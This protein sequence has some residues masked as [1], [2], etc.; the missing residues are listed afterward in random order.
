M[1]K[2]GLLAFFP[3]I[4]VKR[5]HQLISVFSS[6]DEAWQADA[7][8]F[9]KIKWNEQLIEEFVNW[10]KNIDENQTQKILDQENIRCITI[11]N[12]D[13]PNLLK[14]IY[15]P[16]FALFIK[17]EL[18]NDSF[19][20]A[21]V[22]TRKFTAYGKQITQD[23]VKQLASQGITIISGLALGIDSIA[24]ESALDVK[25]KTIAV[26]GSGIDEHHIYPAIHVNLAK[27]IIAGG[28]AIISEYPPGTEPT[29]FTFPKRNRIIAGMSLGT[30]IIEANEK[31]G[32]LITT[33]CALDNNREVFAVPQN[34]TSPT[35]I[36]PNNLLKM[37][38]KLVT[39]VNDILEA[40]NL[41]N[42]RQYVT[43]KAVI[44]DSPTEAKILETLTNEPTHVDVII[45]NSGLNSQTVNSNL[46]LMEMKGKIK[47]L[48]GMM[49]V[50]AR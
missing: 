48:G 29:K 6:L 36:G 7:N 18:N 45:K 47:N 16:P 38:A 15:D 41:Q 49:Y 1:N 11:S 42:A 50:V 3:R 10:R 24:H 32:A 27:K 23:L 39:D 31:S 17:G 26:L 12:K 46:A 44:P 28:G 5:Y 13:Y 4:T 40:L 33:S 20:L 25:G 19:N 35:A 9:K 43:N 14:E 21:V 34:I 8:E 2:E 22:G 37:G 30:L